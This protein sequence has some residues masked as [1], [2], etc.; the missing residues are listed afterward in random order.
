MTAS[1]VKAASRGWRGRRAAPGGL[2]VTAAVNRRAHARRAL[3]LHVLRGHRDR[4]QQRGRELERPG[5]VNTAG[6]IGKFTLGATA[7][8]QMLEHDTRR[9]SA[10]H[11]A[12]APAA[13]GCIANKPRTDFNMRGLDAIELVVRDVCASGWLGNR[14]HGGWS[15]SR[16]APLQNCGRAPSV[17]NWGGGICTSYI[18][19]HARP[20]RSRGPSRGTSRTPRRG[21]LA[22]AN[23]TAG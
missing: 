14:A 9:A 18:F 20:R 3:T 5:R 22:R 8:L 16:R 21:R 15:R 7:G 6:R 4:R 12:D 23:S 17:T 19:T 2:A 1:R 11:S 10:S 13:P